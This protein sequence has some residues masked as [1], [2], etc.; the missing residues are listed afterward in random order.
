MI[1]YKKWL[2]FDGDTGHVRVRVTAALAGVCDLCASC[3]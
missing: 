3:S 1:K 2:D